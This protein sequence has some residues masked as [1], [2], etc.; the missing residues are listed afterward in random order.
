MT[1]H[2]QIYGTDTSTTTRWL[3]DVHIEHSLYF[4]IYIHI[5]S[6][7][8]KM[9]DVKAK[10]ALKPV[11]AKRGHL[12]RVITIGLRKL[13]SEGLEASF[14]KM[15][16]D[17]ITQKLKEVEEL[18][19]QVVAILDEHEIC[20]NDPDLYENELK[21]QTDY[22]FEVQKSLASHR[23]DSP[24]RAD[25]SA[26]LKGTRVKEI[27]LPIFS[28]HQ[29]D[30]MEFKDFLTLFM[31]LI[32]DNPSY[33][34]DTKLL[35]LKSQLRGSA[36]DV[37]KHLSND[38]ESFELAVSFLKKQYMDKDVVVEHHIKKIKEL[39]K[40]ETVE[41]LRTFFN[42]ARTSLYELKRNGYSFEGDTLGS[43]VMSCLICE[44]LPI[45]FKEKLAL[46]VATDYPTCEDLLNNYTDI[47]KSLE[48]MGHD[49]KVRSNPGNAKPI[50]T[51]KAKVTADSRSRQPQGSLHMFQTEVRKETH[52]GPK[53]CKLCSGVHSMLKCTTYTDAR[54]RI[55]RLKQ[56]KLCVNCSGQHETAECHGKKKG[57]RY[58]CTL[59]QSPTHITAVCTV[60]ASSTQNNLC[61]LNGQHG[62]DV[63][64]PSMSVVMS[65]PGK[66]EL[67]RCLVDN[68]SQ[69]SYISGKLAEE[70][71]LSEQG[72]EEEF[73]IK[74]CIGSKQKKHKVVNCD[75][76][77]TPQHKVKAAFL[78]DD[79]M[80]LRYSVP[81]V[82]SVVHQL[83]KAGVKL[84][85]SFFHTQETDT[86][87]GFGC[88][89][90]VD[91]LVHLTPLETVT[92]ERGTAYSVEDGHIL[93]GDINN[94][95]GKDSEQMQTSTAVTC[96][97]GA[98]PQ[99]KPY[100]SQ[101]PAPGVTQQ[102]GSRQQSAGNLGYNAHQPHK[103]SGYPTGSGPNTGQQAL[104]PQQEVPLPH[105]PS[106][107]QPAVQQSSLQQAPTPQQEVPLPQPPSGHQPAVQQSP[108]LQQALTPQ[109]EVPL[110]QPPSGHQP[111]VQ[112]SSQLL[113]QALTPQQEVP[114]PQPPSGQQPAVQQSSQLLQ[115]A[116]TPQQEV[117]LP[118]P[119][120]GHQPAVQQ[121]S[122]LL[123][124]AL[125]P[126][127]EVPL[128]QPPSGHQPAVQQ[129]LQQA[130]T[131]QQEVPLPQ[132][133]SGQQPAVQQSSQLLQQA[134]TPQQEVSLPQ[135]P[136]GHQPAVQQSS[137]PTAGS[138]AT[139]GGVAAPAAF[140]P[141]ASCSAI[142]SPTAG[143]YATAGSAA[144]PAAFRPAASCSTIVSTST[145]G[146]YATA[147][148]VAAPAAFRPSASCSTI[149]STSTAGSY[150]TAGGA[151]APAA[152]RPS[153][154]C[155]TIIST[156]TADT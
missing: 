76:H 38:E 141:S 115:Q 120:S 40:P 79:D 121:S 86:L 21:E 82:S 145:A 123:Q 156:S 110:P 18:D 2:I 43:R 88:L 42:S 149:I 132:P 109:Q 106:G 131:P 113:Q 75:V 144:A 34:G 102:S 153:A 28:G 119:P 72:H 8:A 112:Q 5:H 48:K 124:K 1:D 53:P 74:T 49:K 24:R 89:L 47:I 26:W 17:G 69:A 31:D 35:Y 67:V 10:E 136:S 90:G 56:L 59:C 41:E 71:G 96:Q 99:S 122:Q 30:V 15:Q 125:M 55:S 7:I 4:I 155:S 83:Q 148:G 108:H 103:V 118:Q 133:P 101:A 27:K 45:S 46:K 32:G 142:A 147:G 22:Q 57:L 29:G 54:Q 87:E 127:Q 146:S 139:A 20:A 117:S 66:A 12:K 36:L 137:Q 81:G 98:S 80:D 44:K 52:A 138:Y 13:E 16:I 128:P 64:L 151:A 58:P 104:M 126:Q 19:M 92:V 111:A 105:Q 116:L 68:G 93:F 134:L 60:T 152:F 23:A 50:N 97:S 100:T 150:A 78:V 70:L 95:K 107:H 130:L 63:L 84:A 37:V 91:L 77:V 39:R 11:K 73:N 25:K 85:D 154:S 51:G 140:R 33:Q 61:L 62:Q 135:P 6:S 14:V 143:S 114:L 65:T 94:F 9:A 129:S 3:T